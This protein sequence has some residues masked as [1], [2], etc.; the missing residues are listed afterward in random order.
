M[1]PYYV[2]FSFF[3]LA[4]CLE[5][6][7]Q[8]DLV[9]RLKAGALAIGY[10]GILFFVGFR[11][12]LG[13]DW[14]SYWQLYDTITPFEKMILGENLSFS[15]DYVEPGFKLLMSFCKTIGLNYAMFV[16][17]V[18]TFNTISLYYFLLHNDFRRKLVFLA[19]ILI[20]TTFS[21]FDILRQAF[22]FHIMLFAFRGDSVR[23][24][25]FVF[26]LILSMTFH[27]SVAIFL[28]FY[29][30]LKIKLTRKLV[31]LIAILYFTSMFVTIPFI[32]ALLK[33]IEPFASGA[34]YAVVW[35]AQ[36]LV[37]DFG[38]QR[39][40]SFTSLLNV[41]FLS[42]LYLS[43]GRLRFT[44]AEGRLIKFFLFYIVISFA[45]K[46]IQEVADRF[47]Y[48][49]NI[50]I[51]FMFCLLTDMIRAKERKLIVMFLPLAFILMRLS[52]HFRQE[53]IWYGQTPYRNYLLISDE[54]ETGE[55]IIKERYDKMNALKIQNNEK[56]N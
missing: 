39:N 35:K 47:A 46:E 41:I 2:F 32:K 18:A 15:V 54:D 33:S 23:I 28:L 17:V 53:A 55:L 51:A 21:E 29:F 1:I 8:D 13:S 38:F 45:F 9:R 19:I 42:L 34:L 50:G 27:F 49:F 20:L 25:R 24:I 14:V 7:R 5:F 30:F 6:V 31:L 3:G 26:L 40:I 11:Y 10:I 48:Y 22:A 36:N 4:A 37:S 16:F 56:G 52:L 12:K 44:L 43:W